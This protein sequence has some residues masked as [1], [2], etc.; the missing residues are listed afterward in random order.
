MTAP[1]PSPPR[2]DGDAVRRFAARFARDIMIRARIIELRRLAEQTARGEL[3]APD[4]DPPPKNPRKEIPPAPN[5][6]VPAP[7]QPRTARATAKQ[8]APITQGARGGRLGGDRDRALGGGGPDKSG[9]NLATNDDGRFTHP[10]DPTAHPH[11][12]ERA[13]RRG[14]RQTCG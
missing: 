11:T 4:D 3:P 5:S 12:A 8:V 6:C 13:R 7:S 10:G 1:T 14:I 2:R 9:H